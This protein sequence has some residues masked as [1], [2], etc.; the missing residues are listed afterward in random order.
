V[1]VYYS[2]FAPG[3][4]KWATLM[5]SLTVLALGPHTS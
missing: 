3:Y 4:S 2:M 5:C 1:R